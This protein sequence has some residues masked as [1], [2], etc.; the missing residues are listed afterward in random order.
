MILKLEIE[1]IRKEITK[2]ELMKLKIQRLQTK[3][4]VEIEEF[5]SRLEA[6]RNLIIQK[7]FATCENDNA[8]HS[9]IQNYVSSLNKIDQKLSNEKERQ[10]KV[11]NEQ[12]IRKITILS[13]KQRVFEEKFQTKFKLY[14]F[15]KQSLW[16]LK[17]EMNQNNGEG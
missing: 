14:I 12:F 16:K 5:K 4:E 7:N 13:E 3:G 1:H 6:K 9:I 17:K 15:R 8:N 10:L 11:R 2:I